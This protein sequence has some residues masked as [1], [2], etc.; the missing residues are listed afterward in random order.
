MRNEQN[1]DTHLI[2]K[3][4]IYMFQNLLIYLFFFSKWIPH[5]NI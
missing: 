5:S 2:F 4:N 3:K 1:N